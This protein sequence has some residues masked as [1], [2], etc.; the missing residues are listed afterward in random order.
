[1]AKRKGSSTSQPR[2]RS[3]AAKTGSKAKISERGAA[4]A[5]DEKELCQLRCEVYP[6]LEERDKLW[7]QER[8]LKEE[9]K[10][11]KLK[12]EWSML[13]HNLE[14]PGLSREAR[15]LMEDEERWNQV[16]RE[17]KVK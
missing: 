5:D 4:A 8:E 11:E 3:K 1:M 17:R 16:E 6:L 14:R 9:L 10:E 2:T 13:R 12:V 15:R 7:E